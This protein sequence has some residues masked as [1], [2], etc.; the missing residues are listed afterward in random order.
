MDSP[1]T[2][3]CA[4]ECDAQLL[5]DLSRKLSTLPPSI[6]SFAI[7]GLQVFHGT[8]ATSAQSI[9]RKGPDF[10]LIGSANGHWY[11]RG[12]YTT[13]FID[14]AV[15]YATSTGV[16]CVCAATLGNIKRGDRGC[17]DDTAGSLLKEGY[18]SVVAASNRI[19]VLFHPDSVHVEYIINDVADTTAEK[20]LAAKQAQ[21]DVV[22]KQEDLVRQKELQVQPCFC[23]YAFLC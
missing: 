5:C 10:T 1:V 22:W 13:T 2:H 18:H 9:A 15:S 7:F 19:T 6:C 16:V 17:E 3:A 21:L 23:M 14:T 12:F 4:A 20:A 11:G 8:K